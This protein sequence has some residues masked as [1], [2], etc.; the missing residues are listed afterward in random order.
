[1][2]ESDWSS[3]YEEFVE[4]D[5]TDRKGEEKRKEAKPR[6][7]MPSETFYLHYF[8]DAYKCRRLFL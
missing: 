4:N 2:S 7:T 1:V 8:T 6:L 3:D 5:A